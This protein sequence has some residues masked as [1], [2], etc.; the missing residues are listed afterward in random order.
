LDRV[1]RVLGFFASVLVP[2]T[3]VRIVR[4][5]EEAEDESPDPLSASIESV[6]T[7]AFNTDGARFFG[8]VIEVD[9]IERMV[10]FKAPILEEEFEGADDS[11]APAATAT[12]SGSGFA[13]KKPKNALDLPSGVMADTELGA[14]KSVVLV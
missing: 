3:S 5:F 13:D 2:R 8:F 12:S 9:R 6:L 14:G 11:T 1:A 10:S 7:T 4:I